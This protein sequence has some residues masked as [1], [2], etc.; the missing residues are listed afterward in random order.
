MS[1]IHILTPRSRR[2]DRAKPQHIVLLWN[3]VRKARKAHTLKCGC[4]IQPGTY[5]HSTGMLIKGHFTYAKQ[6][7]LGFC[8]E[9]V[10]N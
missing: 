4:T 7:A 6:H 10:P 5:Y 1:A 3:K 2:L 8:C 9:P